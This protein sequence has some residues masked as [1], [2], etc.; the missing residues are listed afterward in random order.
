MFVP[1]TAVPV[2]ASQPPRPDPGH[3][4]PVLGRWPL[5]PRGLAG[6][7]PRDDE[8][9]HARGGRHD[10]GVGAT[11]SWSPSG[12]TSSC[13][14]VS[15]PSP[16]S[17]RRRSSSAS[18]CSGAGSRR[19]PRA[20]RPAR[21]IGW[22]ASARRP[23]SSCATATDHEV[24]LEA[25]AV[26]DLLRVRP[27]DRIPV[28]GVVV[29]G[30][31]AVDASMLTGEPIPRRG[32]AGRR[33]HRG[34]PEHDRHVRDAR[35][36]GRARH[37]AGPDRRPRPAR[38]G[39]EGA[40]PAPRRPGRRGVRAA[41]PGRRGG[42]LRRLVRRRPGAAPDPRPDLVHRGPRHRLPVR[43]GPGDADRDHGRD[44][45]GRGGRHP[46]PR[47][48]GARD[49]PSGRHG[50]A[51]QDRHADRRPP[52]DRRDR[53]G[54]RRD[55][56]R[57]ARPG[58]LGREGERAPGRGGDPR[59]GARGRARLPAR[60]GL[61]GDRRARRR[62]HDRWDADPRRDR[63][64]SLREHGIDVGLAP[65]RRGPGRRAGDDA[66]LGGG[67]GPSARFRPGDRRA[68]AGRSRGGRG[69]ARVRASM[70]GS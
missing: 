56:R 35:D 63:P 22:S 34:D 8:H 68:Q 36:A 45:S 14:P 33:G 65:G 47:R 21:S 13:R 55:A 62:G 50:R 23:R 61:P 4:H 43:D 17:I 37:G 5:L 40:D 60:R 46:H 20:G 53:H 57:A 15:S 64:A 67:R 28:D 18:S 44:R 24:P 3:V 51:R 2:T 38:P 52:V 48:R 10:G 19:V 39:L 32:R 6:G 31:S 26:G 12:P 66:G 11:A 42:D 49:R 58:R 41:R 54:A 16:T 7:P 27:G 1:Q 70:S 29:E 30:G 69:A 25:V 59:P 9:G